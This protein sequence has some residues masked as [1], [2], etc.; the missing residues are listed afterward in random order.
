VGFAVVGVPV[1]VAVEGFGVAFS[2]LPYT[3]FVCSFVCLGAAFIEMQ[4]VLYLPVTS[5]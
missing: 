4:R 2:H 3:S 5:S 1:G